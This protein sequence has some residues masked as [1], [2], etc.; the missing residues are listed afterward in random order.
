VVPALIILSA[1]FVVYYIL[2]RF[3]PV[4]GDEPEGTER[5]PEGLLP[6]GGTRRG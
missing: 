1:P 4:L 2:S 3:I 5:S 6:P